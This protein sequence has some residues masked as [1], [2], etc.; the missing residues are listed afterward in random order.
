MLLCESNVSC[1]GTDVP[2][3]FRVSSVL[4]LIIPL[5]AFEKRKIMRWT[6]WHSCQALMGSHY[7]NLVH[8]LLSYV[9]C[10]DT[11]FYLVFWLWAG[12]CDLQLRG[13]LHAQGYLPGGITSSG[14]PFSGHIVRGITSRLG[15]AANVERVLCT[16]R[17]N[18]SDSCVPSQLY[19]T[20]SSL[21]RFGLAHGDVVISC[22]LTYFWFSGWLALGP[23]RLFLVIVTHRASRSEDWCRFF[24]LCVALL[25]SEMYLNYCMRVAI[26]WVSATLFKDF[27]EKLAGVALSRIATLTILTRV[28]AMCGG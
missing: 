16:L 24:R 25:S 10:L 22:M 27:L 8:R 18:A 20:S 23:A 3:F 12:D 14:L 9:V 15:L 17:S 13:R 4:K 11:F 21:S 2:C 26:V 7:Q 19:I 28:K 6:F 1:S 5:L